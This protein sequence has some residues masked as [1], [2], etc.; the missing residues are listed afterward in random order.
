MVRS[1]KFWHRTILDIVDSS[2]LCGVCRV[3]IRGTSIPGD[4]FW[5]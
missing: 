5:R 3:F 2:A 4:V 1:S